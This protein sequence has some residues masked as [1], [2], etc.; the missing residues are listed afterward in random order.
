LRKKKASLS[1]HTW[2]T[3]FI[4]AKAYFC[5]FCLLLFPYQPTLLFLFLIPPEHAYHSVIPNRQNCQLCG[6]GHLQTFLRFFSS[7]VFLFHLF[8]FF[9]SVFVH[10]SLLFNTLFLL[11]NTLFPYNRLPNA[12]FSL[13]FLLMLDLFF[14]YST[15]SF[16]PNV[17]SLRPI[18]LHNIYNIHL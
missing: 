4:L 1:Q 9:Y 8:F 7:L 17:F 2:M 16:Y 5:F 3:F 6:N 10:R 15:F 13:P 12:S 18:T 14:Y 11:L